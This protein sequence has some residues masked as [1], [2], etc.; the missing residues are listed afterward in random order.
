MKPP[1]FVLGIESSC[2]ETAVA[3]VSEA[4]EMLANVVCSQT[5]LHAPY[6]GVVPEIA[7]RSHLQWLEP[8][9]KEALTQ[10]GLPSVA[11][12]DAIAATSGPGLIGGLIVGLMSGKMLASIYRKPLFAVNHLEAHALTV[13]LTDGL[14][15][16]YLLLLVSGGHCFFARINGLG[17]YEHLGGTIDDALG[18]AFDKCAK[19]MGLSYP[20]GPA[21]ERLAATGDASAFALPRP[22][23]GTTNQDHCDLS[24]AGLKTAIRTQLLAQDAIDAKV[25]AN[26]AAAFQRTVIA[27]LCEKVSA[28]Y[29]LAAR[30]D[31]AAP[32]PLVLA[33]GVAANQAIKAALVAHCEAKHGAQC[34]VPPPALCTDNA[35]MIAWVGQERLQSGCSPDP[36]TAEPRARWPLSSV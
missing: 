25:Q 31:D 18:E 20:G 13:R 3:I 23:C 7:A 17:D 1:R 8:A 35:A 26:M 12:M 11:S 27:I 6:G 32:L 33:G 2:D 16:P 22:L 28:A 24:F 5:D 15:Y 21:I 30:P 19:M 34:V 9:L 29:R 14:P 4:R 36:L 10:A